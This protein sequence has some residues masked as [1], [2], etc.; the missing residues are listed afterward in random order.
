MA[1]PPTASPT[2]LAGLQGDLQKLLAT[3]I[4]MTVLIVALGLTWAYLAYGPIVRDRPRTEIDIQ[5][6]VDLVQNRLE[7]HQE[8]IANEMTSLLAEVSPPLAEAFAQRFA[9]DLST[10]MATLQTEGS[11]LIDRLQASF[12]ERLEERWEP[13]VDE[14]EVVIARET[15]RQPDDPSVRALT[16]RIAQSA[17]SAAERYHLVGLHTQARTTGTVWS[18]IEP[19]PPPP[20]G[21]PPHAEQLTRYLGDWLV[22]TLSEE[23]ETRVGDALNQR[24]ATP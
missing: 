3:S 16:E 20:P 24:G 15:G 23:L 12:A 14:V 2:D 17:R 7:A 13:F 22:L 8:D 5:P 9:E 10:Y 21:D 18:N 19:L 1:D 4:L 11:V 6:M